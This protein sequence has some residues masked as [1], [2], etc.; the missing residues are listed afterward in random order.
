MLHFILLLWASLFLWSFSFLLPLF[1]LF[2]LTYFVSIFAAYDHAASHF[3]IVSFHIFCEAFHSCF[4]CS[5]CW[6][7]SII[8]VILG[9]F[10]GSLLGILYFSISSFN[11]FSIFIITIALFIEL[12]FFFNFNPL[13]ILISAMR[14]CIILS[15]IRCF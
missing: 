8:F 3:I 7:L 5:F 4:L 9:L 1:I 15:S 2:N 11:Y 13:F 12:S 10:K 6:S 14:C